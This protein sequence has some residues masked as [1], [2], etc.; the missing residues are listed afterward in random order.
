MKLVELARKS[1]SYLKEAG[2][3]GIRS[4]ELA[5]ILGVPKRRV[6]DVVAV[7]KAL[8]QVT[9]NRRFNG[10]TVVWLDRTK[11]YVQRSEYEDIKMQLENE[12]CERK[13]LQ[14][15][16]AETKE[17]LRRTKSK[18]RLDVQPTISAEKTEFNTTQLRIRSLSS[19]G[20]KRVADSGL[21]V[22]I[23]TYESGMV[24]DPSEIE[25]DENEALLKSLQRL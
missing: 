18:L 12:R 20:F 5:E 24:V 19:K 16:L 3:E 10:T 9:T 15:Q 14:T 11:N 13:E 8:S 1:V 23:E 22:I 6:Y 4:D 21:E 17:N 2:E 7:L 25:A